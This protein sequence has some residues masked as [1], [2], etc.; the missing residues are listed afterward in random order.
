MQEEQSLPLNFFFF[1]GLLNLKV[2]LKPFQATLIA[3]YFDQQLRNSSSSL[4]HSFMAV[5]ALE[6]LQEVA[7]LEQKFF[8]VNPLQDKEIKIKVLNSLGQPY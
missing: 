5:S 7:F 6:K 2:N 4:C 3:N 1:Q 8:S